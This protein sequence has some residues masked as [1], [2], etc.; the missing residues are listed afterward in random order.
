[1]I[2]SHQ[3]A[4]GTAK[5]ITQG[6]GT[7]CPSTMSRVIGSPCVGVR[8]FHHGVLMQGGRNTQ[9]IPGAVGVV[10][11]I[12]DLNREGCGEAGKRRGH[13]DARRITRLGHDQPFLVQPGEGSFDFRQW[14]SQRLRHFGCGRWPGGGGNG[15]VNLELDGGIKV[16]YFRPDPGLRRLLYTISAYDQ[17]LQAVLTSSAYN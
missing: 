11:F 16:H 13:A 14:C 4:A 10:H 3:R 9:S 7:G 12:L 2:S 6:S 8:G 17:C 5:W 15:V 1:M